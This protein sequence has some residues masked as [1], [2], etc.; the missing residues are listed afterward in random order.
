MSAGGHLTMGRTINFGCGLRDTTVSHAEFCTR[1]GGK[2]KERNYVTFLGSH[3][4]G[5]IGQMAG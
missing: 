2:V 3:Q 5:N 1:E 4:T